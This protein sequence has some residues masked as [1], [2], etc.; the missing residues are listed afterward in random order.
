MESCEKRVTRARE[1]RQSKEVMHRIYE[2]YRAAITEIDCAWPLSGA[3]RA[4]SFFRWRK[5]TRDSPLR[6]SWERRA[7]TFVVVK[8]AASDQSLAAA[9][10][11][12]G[13]SA[14]AG[15]GNGVIH[16]HQKARV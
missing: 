1:Q 7:L 14:Y 6:S 15:N 13:R 11:R 12:T 9:I 16:A 8:A 10:H 5:T 3:S 4:I 2:I